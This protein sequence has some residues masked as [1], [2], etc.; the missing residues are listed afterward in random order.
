MRAGLVVSEFAI[1]QGA[2]CPYLP[3]HMTVADVVN[4][5][6]L[7]SHNQHPNKTCCGKDTRR[8]PAPAG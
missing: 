3:V 6:A 7:L 5:V 8:D 4:S 1:E 2:V